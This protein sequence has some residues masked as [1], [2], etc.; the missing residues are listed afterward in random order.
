MNSISLN[1]VV[2]A[3]AER[4]TSA[5]LTWDDTGYS[6]VVGFDFA[7]IE[8]NPVDDEW[9]SGESIPVVLYDKDANQNSRFDEDLDL[10]NPDV[11]LVPS[12]QIGSPLTLESL[13]TAT[14]SG[15]RVFD[16]DGDANHPQEDEVQAF[17]QRAMLQANEFTGSNDIVIAAGDN[18]IFNYGVN[19]DAVADVWG[20]I[21]NNDV[22][23]E[24]VIN[25]FNYDIR[26]IFDTGLDDDVDGSIDGFEIYVGGTDATGIRLFDTDNNGTFTD[27]SGD[28]AVRQAE[29]DLVLG[30]NQALPLVV[31]FHA[32][33][34]ADTPTLRDETITPVV[35]DF[36]SFGFSDDG[37]QS[38]ERITNMIVRLELEENGDNTGEFEG[39]IE[40]VMLNQLN[41]LDVG[42]YNGIGTIADD[43][44]I[45]VYEDFTDEDSVRIN[46][47]DLAEDGTRLPVADQEEAPSHSGSVSFDLD[48][49]KVADTV[50]ITLE[51]LDLNVDSDLREIYT[52][53]DDANDSAY[54]SVGDDN[55]P[56]FQWGS[57]G[58]LLNVTFDDAAWKDPQTLCDNAAGDTL[59]DQVGTDRGLGGTGF[60]LVETD[61]DSGVFIG[62]FA[63]PS[64]WCRVDDNN[65]AL[66]G[67]TETTTGLDI[68]VNYI[69]F[70][71][72]SGEIIEVGDGAGIRANTGSVSLDR[73]VYPVPFGVVDDF[74]ADPNESSPDG[75]AI[76]PVHSTGITDGIDDANG[77]EFLNGG[78]LTIHVRINDPDFDISPD[79]EDSIATAQDGS[80]NTGPLKISVIR[81]S[82]SVVLGYAGGPDAEAADIWVGDAPAI[83]DAAGESDDL[84]Q[85]GPISETAPDSGIFE[86]D[87]GIAFSDGPADDR[88]PTT[89]LYRATDDADNRA[90]DPNNRFTDADGAVDADDD[91]CILQGDIL[92]VEYT[93]PTD[94]SGDEN[95]V[96]DSATFDLR[97]GCTTN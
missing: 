71:D 42:T 76:F 46:Y 37:E 39:E 28:F 50:V 5:T 11:D 40:Y 59:E 89:T 53:V 10:N 1:L 26:S 74:V 23:R 78:D 41:I 75:R 49:Y 91:F 19:N 77:V 88:C 96:T 58:N 4:G 85:F 69:D 66:T 61:T 81:S 3:N 62:D 14:L 36:F 83:G 64:A 65:D 84:Q 90:A 80:D 31:T 12:I 82:N 27:F 29:V 86:L 25:T 45:I 34:V 8:I 33:T 94:A 38:S 93:D 52:V 51:D 22:G 7:S 15:D 20:S 24:Q 21:D 6:A 35:V 18:L 13:G 79:G 16:S 54:E 30:L 73:T 44:V 43:P 60:T 63:V 56:T 55:L 92:Q 17:S 57:M 97:N 48:T 67:D 9:N 72:A 47:N 70:R 68:E 87:L 2:T 32:E 95:T